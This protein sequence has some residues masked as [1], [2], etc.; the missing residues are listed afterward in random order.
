MHCQRGLNCIGHE[1]RRNEGAEIGWLISMQEIR[2]VG[3]Q[4]SSGFDRN[5]TNRSSGSRDGG[6][7]LT[8]KRSGCAG[9]LQTSSSH[10][11][12]YRI[13]RV[14]DKIGE[15][16]NRPRIAARRALRLFLPGGQA[17][18]NTR[19]NSVAKS[20]GFGYTSCTF[21]QLSCFCPIFLRSN[22]YEINSSSPG[23]I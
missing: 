6:H 12:H 8:R 4:C 7:P 5:E 2:L 3:L 22:M 9:P 21:L 18:V 11:F 1:D 15:A 20:G 17:P 16:E 13:W 19:R 14:A 10:H 23:A